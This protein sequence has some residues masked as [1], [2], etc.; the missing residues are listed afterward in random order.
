LPREEITQY[1][2]ML[3]PLAEIAPDHQHPVLGESYAH[4]WAAY[5]KTKANQQRIVPPWQLS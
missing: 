3:E 5:D 1:A 2:F 4:L